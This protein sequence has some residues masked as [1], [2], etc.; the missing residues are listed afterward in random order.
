LQVG[1]DGWRKGRP[2]RV[3][4]KEEDKDEAENAGGFCTAVPCSTFLYSCSCSKARS[5]DWT[6]GVGLG[7]VVGGWRLALTLPRGLPYPRYR[8]IQKIAL[9]WLAAPLTAKEESDSQACGQNLVVNSRCIFGSIVLLALPYFDLLHH[10]A[11]T[12][13]IISRLCRK[14]SIKP[15]NSYFVVIS[16]ILQL[17]C[18][19]DLHVQTPSS[20][21]KWRFGQKPSE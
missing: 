12:S 9:L 16:H 21:L 20:S 14:A 7:C 19:E 8:M 13:E 11:Q 10:R 1:T 3:V 5:Q 2:G 17:A 15:I 4:E 18:A 6:L